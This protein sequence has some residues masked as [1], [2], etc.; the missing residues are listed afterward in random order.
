MTSR[1]EEVLLDDGVVLLT[2]HW[3]APAPA[4]SIVIVHGAGDHSGRWEHVG[5][6]LSGKGFDVHAYDMRGHGRSGGRP[7]FVEHF[8]DFLDDLE[9]IVR[10][11]AAAG[12]PVAVYGH[13]AGGLVALAYAVDERPQPHCYVLT[14]PALGSTTPKALRAAAYLLGGLLPKATVPTAFKM[15]QLSRDPAV[16]DA[17]LADPHVHGKGSLRLGR[18]V[19]AAMADTRKRLSRLR[20]PTLV[21]HGA[22]DGLVPPAVS[23]P[24]AALAV[25]ERRVLAGLRHELHNEPERDEVLDLIARW[26]EGQVATKDA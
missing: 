2:R 7:M 11:A 23:A 8:D 12:K 3:A 6:Y 13:S 1:T 14:A 17:Y 26:L 10:R 20:R 4:A 21:L 19:F 22:D 5:D 18:E 9:V 15:E 24:L 25:V 16:G